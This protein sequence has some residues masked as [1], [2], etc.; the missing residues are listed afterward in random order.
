MSSGICKT[1]GLVEEVEISITNF[2][3]HKQCE[4]NKSVWKKKKK[5]VILSKHILFNHLNNDIGA[6]FYYLYP[7]DSTT[8]LS[9]LFINMIRGMNF[10]ALTVVQC[11]C[12]SAHY[13]NL[14]NNTYV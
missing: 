1:F 9:S 2:D 8:S 3:A 11:S 4:L 10:D 6:S 5:S 14:K 7:Q 13:F 12:N